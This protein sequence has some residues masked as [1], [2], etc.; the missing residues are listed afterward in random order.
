MTIYLGT[1]EAGAEDSR[2]LGPPFKELG[3]RR[4][5]IREAGRPIKEPEFAIPRA[6]THPLAGCLPY[7]D[8]D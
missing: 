5:H 3:W 6:L 8:R 1:F 2:S 4:R 7:D